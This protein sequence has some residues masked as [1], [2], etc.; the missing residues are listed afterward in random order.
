MADLLLRPLAESDLDAVQALTGEA[1]S[2]FNWSGHRTMQALRQRFDRDGYL[3]LED[4]WLV[5]SDA[6][7]A[8]LGT[9]GW[10][11]VE[12]SRPPY[13]RAWNLG[14]T[15]APAERGRGVGIAAHVLLAEYLFLTTSVRRVEAVTNAANLA[16]R[17]A[18]TKAGFSPEGVLRKAEFRFGDWHDLHMF[19][20]LRDEWTVKRQVPPPDAT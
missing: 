19:S 9:V 12:W 17:S 13:S 14:I 5:I 3:G 10:N 20:L 2:G 1:A 7:S 18:L 8:V 16:E 4:G 11:A 15:V 6:T